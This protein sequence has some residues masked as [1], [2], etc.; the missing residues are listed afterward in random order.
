MKKN[1]IAIA[2]GIVAPLPCLAQSS[3][4]LYGIIDEGLTVT[5]NQAG[6]RNY[7][8]SSLGLQASRWGFKGREDLGSGTA[9]IFVLESGFDP[10]S[11]TLGQGG[12]IFG[13][14]AYVGLS[15]R[16]GTF[17]TGRQYGPVV[18]SFQSLTINGGLA[19]PMFAHPLDNDDTD[20]TYHSN[21]SIKYQ[22]PNISGLTGSIQYAFSNAA[23]DFANNRMWGTALNYAHGPLVVAGTFEVFDSPGLHT[24]TAANPNGAI[25]DGS[26]ISSRQTITGFG[27][28]YTVGSA[29]LGLVWTH[30]QFFN[31]GAAGNSGIS[32]RFNNYEANVTYQFTPAVLAALAYTYTTTNI[33]DPGSA[34]RQSKIHQIG[35]L[36]DYALSKRTDVYTELAYQHAGGG[37][38][39]ANASGSPVANIYL[40]PTSSTQNQAILRVGMRHKF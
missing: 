9:A 20:N 16:Y 39:F 25:V 2:L 6:H 5:T 34:E 28:N 35:G 37:A 7:Q 12:R 30:T 29:K 26:I 13:R 17:T 19:G 18:D 4:T 38:L 10:T 32:Y 40:L 11:G 33:S 1:I 31:V 24:G 15:T 8:L 36:L 27:A 23:G 21:N 22:L 14:Q 3:V